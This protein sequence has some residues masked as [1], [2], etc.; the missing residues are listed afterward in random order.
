VAA[1][2]LREAALQHV[3]RRV[4]QPRVDVAQLLD[5]AAHVAVESSKGLKPVSHFM[6]ST[7]RFQAMWFNRIQLA[8]PHLQREQVRRVLRVLELQQEG[9]HEVRLITVV[10]L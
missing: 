5:V 10:F 9:S 1:L 6:V 2:E 7:G 4:H 3:R 8:Q